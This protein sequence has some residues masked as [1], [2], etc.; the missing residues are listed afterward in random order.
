M[1]IGHLR[2]TGLIQRMREI[3]VVYTIPHADNENLPPLGLFRATREL[4]KVEATIS[5]LR[6]SVPTST[7]AFQA[8]GPLSSSVFPQHCEF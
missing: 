4:S 2:Y 3:E 5:E 8:S 7:V 6:P 1:R